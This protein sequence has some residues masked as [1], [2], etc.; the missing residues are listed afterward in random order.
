MDLNVNQ[1]DVTKLAVQ[2]GEVLVVRVAGTINSEFYARL[3][4]AF[5][6]AF[7]RGG[8]F[9]PPILVVDDRIVEITAAKAEGALELK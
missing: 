3:A 7:N 5:K 1:V 8:G 4:F 9:V 6:D 2:P